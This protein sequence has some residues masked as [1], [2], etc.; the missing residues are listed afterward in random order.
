MKRSEMIE[1]LAKYLK[2]NDQHIGFTKDLALIV[3]K[4]AIDCVEK[5]GMLPPMYE[6]WSTGKT[7]RAIDGYVTSDGNF[8][9]E[10][11]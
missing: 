1:E 6:D 7:Y 8:C 9:W 10:E 5:R 11:E 3:A 2:K 4:K